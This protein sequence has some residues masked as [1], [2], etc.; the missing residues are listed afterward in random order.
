MCKSEELEVKLKLEQYYESF[1]YKDWAKFGDCIS[2]NFS[3]FSDNAV[4]MNKEDYIDF[5]RKNTFNGIEYKIS[6][7]KVFISGSSDLAAAFYRTFFR[8]TVKGNE[9]TVTAFETSV[10]IK[11]SNNWK[12]LHTHISNKQ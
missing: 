10:F 9:M 1:H 7:L 8:G 6:D 12:I 3:Y 5:L 11:E 2:N 4:N